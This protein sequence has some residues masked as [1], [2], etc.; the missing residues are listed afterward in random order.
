MLEKGVVYYLSSKS[1][2]IDERGAATLRNRLLHVQKMIV[3]G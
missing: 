3:L 1:V 2:Q